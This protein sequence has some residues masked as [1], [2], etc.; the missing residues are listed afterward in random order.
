MKLKGVLNFILGPETAD[1]SEEPFCELY[2]CTREKVPRF[3]L[4]RSKESCFTEGPEHALKMLTV[5]TS[6]LV[7]RLGLGA[8]STGGPF[9][10]LE[11]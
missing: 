2:A 11:T 10:S 9:L 4:Q 6:L 1:S 8:P 7:Q 5:W 3:R